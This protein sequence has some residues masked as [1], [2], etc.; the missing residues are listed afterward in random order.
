[1][2]LLR[3]APSPTGALHLGG[4]RT[5]LY[6]H[7]YA[8]KLGGKWLLRVDDTDAV[9]I[10]PRSPSHRPNFFCWEYQTRFVPEAMEGIRT[11][12]SWAGLD[13]DFGVYYASVRYIFR[14][15][16]RALL[17]PGKGGPHEPYVQS[18]RLDLYHS[19]ANKLLDV[20]YLSSLFRAK[21]FKPSHLV[22]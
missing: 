6:N 10:Q 16:T 5:A 8:K 1:M 12:L 22:N 13:Y 11:A 19:Y 17:G 3:F 7:L 9:S 18:Q 14:W 15:L 20:M 21:M 4:L 2:A